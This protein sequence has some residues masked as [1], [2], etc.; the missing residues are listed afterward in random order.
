MALFPKV[1]ELSAI[2]K[3]E[4]KPDTFCWKKRMWLPQKVSMFFLSM[5]HFWPLVL[6]GEVGNLSSFDQ[7]WWPWGW[8]FDPKNCFEFKFP[9]FAPPPTPQD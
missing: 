5:K 7:L 9:A 4:E 6:V 3:L 8:A 1:S 2:Q